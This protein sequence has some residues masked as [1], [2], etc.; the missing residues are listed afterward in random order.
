MVLELATL[1]RCGQWV[2]V[3]LTAYDALL[4][5]A[6][7]PDPAPLHPGGQDQRFRVLVPAHDEAGVIA[8]VVTDLQRQTHDPR[9]VR[10]VVIADRCGD[11]TAAAAADAGAEAR[12]RD[13]GPEGKGAALAW[14]LA[15]EPLQEDEAVVVLD[16]DTRVPADLLSS[17]AAALADGSGVL[18]ANLDVSNPDVSLVALASALS[19]WSGNRMV[20]H[21]RTRLGWSADLGGTGMCLSAASLSASG[22]FSSAFAEDRDLALRVVLCG[23]QVRWLHD[24][25]ILDE[26][27]SDAVT[28]VRQR[29]R[30]RN[31]D[32]DVRQRHLLPLLRFAA[33][34]RSASAFDHA[35]R[36]V[37]PGRAVLAAATLPLALLAGSRPRVGLLAPGVWGAA[38]GTQVLLPM[39]FLARDGVAL[40]HLLRYPIVTL[41]AAVAVPIQVVAPR[42]RG[43]WVHT[44]HVG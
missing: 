14:Y 15:S 29:A 33:A 25:R 19:Y 3:G 40:R 8:N 34:H 43:R 1:A 36:L 38:V 42:V 12:E 6:G 32:R 20:Q 31:A 9:L 10:I 41:V 26:K 7:W 22:G 18:Q 4:A 39:V 11:A 44:P 24:V 2:L 13:E 35:V 28:A 30:W 16:A 21:A 17:F 23:G 37:R 27:P 5:L